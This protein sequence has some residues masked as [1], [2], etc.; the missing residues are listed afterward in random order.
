M[1][2]V[3]F[4]FVPLPYLILAQDHRPNTFF[5]E[6]FKESQ[7]QIPITQDHI[8]NSDLIISLYGEG[9]DMIKKSN[10]VQPYDDPNYVWSGLYK[11]NWAVTIKHKS[12]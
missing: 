2:N 5:C 9:A 4:I 7:L 8:I 10:H 3:I 11:D 6:D 1:K 12:G